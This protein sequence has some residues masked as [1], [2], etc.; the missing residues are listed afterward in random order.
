VLG[1]TRFD[2][3]SVMRGPI[4]L[5][6][7]TSAYMMTEVCCANVESCFPQAWRSPGGEPTRDPAAPDAAPCCRS[8]LQR[9][10]LALDDAALDSSALLVDAE[11]EYGYLF[12]AFRPT[13]SGRPTNSSG[14]WPADRAHQSDAA[15]ARRR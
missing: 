5:D 15:A 14:R 1:T 13:S 11:S 10:R 7:G 4:V 6:M 8:A 3:G 9:F 12:V 2:C